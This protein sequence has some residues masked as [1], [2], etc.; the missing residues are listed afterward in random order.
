MCSFMKA[1]TGIEVEI[2]LAQGVEWYWGSVVK[3]KL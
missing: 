3:K 1:D 2:D